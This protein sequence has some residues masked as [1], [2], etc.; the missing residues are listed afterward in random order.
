[1]IIVKRKG[2][3]NE[4]IAGQERLAAD[5]PKRREMNDRSEKKKAGTKCCVLFILHSSDLEGVQG[6]ELFIYTGTNP[7]ALSC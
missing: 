2:K 3:C 7:G 1:M 5:D 4:I 6:P